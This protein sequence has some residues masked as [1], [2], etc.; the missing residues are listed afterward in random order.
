MKNSILRELFKRLAAAPE[1]VANDY[2]NELQGHDKE[3]AERLIK[4]LKIKV[5]GERI[6]KLPE[7]IIK[8]LAIMENF[9]L[10]YFENSLYDADFRIMQAAICDFLE[11]K[12]RSYWI[13]LLKKENF[14]YYGTDQREKAEEKINAL[15]KNVK[16]I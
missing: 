11:L 2:L 16:D 3:E 15:L 14:V 9:R 13:D 10:L 8:I 6:M 7:K 12:D 1:I 4:A 5:K